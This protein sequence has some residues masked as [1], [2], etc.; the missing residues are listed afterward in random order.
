M[1][2]SH[3]HLINQAGTKVPVAP[4]TKPKVYKIVPAESV[5]LFGLDRTME[6]E[7]KIHVET[8]AY[9]IGSTALNVPFMYLLSY[10]LL[11]TTYGLA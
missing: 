6:Q 5:F 10:N 3:T 1:H 7:Q 2:L 9:Q 4:S 8:P 11:F